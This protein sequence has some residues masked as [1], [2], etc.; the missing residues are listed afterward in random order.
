MKW[1]EYT[2]LLWNSAQKVAISDE[3]PIPHIPTW[4]RTLTFD[5]IQF[6]DDASFHFAEHW[7]WPPISDHN[8]RYQL[9]FRCL[10]G[11]ECVSGFD[12][13]GVPDVPGYDP[14]ITRRFLGGLLVESWG[15]ESLAWADTKFPGDKPRPPK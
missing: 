11:M 9:Y 14:E 8:V 15:M 10:Y 3:G 4:L 13:D 7:D 6:A 12:R 5:Q 2:N 1:I